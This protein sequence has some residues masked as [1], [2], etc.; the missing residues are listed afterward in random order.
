MLPADDDVFTSVDDRAD[1]DWAGW[2][3]EFLI[4]LVW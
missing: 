4:R 3:L 1:R 2:H